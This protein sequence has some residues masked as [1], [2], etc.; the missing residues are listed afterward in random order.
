MEKLHAKARELILEDYLAKAKEIHKQ[1]TKKWLR[2]Y[3][4]CIFIFLPWILFLQLLNNTFGKRNEY[5]E[6]SAPPGVIIL[7][8]IS[9]GLLIYFAWKPRV[10]RK[11]AIAQVEFTRP[12]FKEFVRQNEHEIGT[13][14]PKK[15]TNVAVWAVF[16]I[17]L[18]AVMALGESA[19]ESQPDRDIRDIKN[20]LG[21]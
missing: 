14:L 17:I 12:G 11:R 21:M 10:W 9:I 4:G 19:S 15:I 2:F 16:G 5:G 1:D 18:L 6:I 20:R 8:I 3:S 13:P 7:A